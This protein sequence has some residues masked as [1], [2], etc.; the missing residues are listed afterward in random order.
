ME[1]PKMGFYSKNAYFSNMRYEVHM[2][3]GLCVGEGVL[4][5][6]SRC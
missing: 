6:F 1:T 4:Y 2:V 5:V 3:K